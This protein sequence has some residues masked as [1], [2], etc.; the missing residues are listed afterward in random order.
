LC[1]V[2]GAGVHF[3]GL[4]HWD[5]IAA[6][7]RLGLGSKL[8][9]VVNPNYTGA[10]TP[11]ADKQPPAHASDPAGATPPPEGVST[12]GGAAGELPGSGPSAADK[13]KEGGEKGSGL[14]KG[15]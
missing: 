9:C 3:Y 2:N 6:D 14:P 12:A 5:K 1:G 4:G 13:D 8:A 7:E 11:A 10:T 15:G